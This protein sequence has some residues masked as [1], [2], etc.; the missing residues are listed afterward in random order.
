[1]DGP[2]Q[3]CPATA[4]ATAFGRGRTTAA[5]TQSHPLRLNTRYRVKLVATIS[6]IASG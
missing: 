2:G 4:R 6:A 5:E 1:V 3:G